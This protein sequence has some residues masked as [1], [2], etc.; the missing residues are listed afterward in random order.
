MVRRAPF[1][2]SR[3][4]ASIEH[5][6]KLLCVCSATKERMGQGFCELMQWHS[7]QA[8][9]DVLLSYDLDRAVRLGHKVDVHTVGPG[10]A[11]VV[12]HSAS[13]NGVAADKSNSLLSMFKLKLR[14]K[15][16]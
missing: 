10:P 5:S 15:H 1:P 16:V 2:L 13:A 6:M 3:I 11:G 4:P 14:F 9:L 7:S 12:G 8:H